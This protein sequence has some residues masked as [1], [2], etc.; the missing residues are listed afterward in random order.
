MLALMCR[1][2]RCGRSVG[3]SECAV[4]KHGSG[5]CGAHLN[6]ETSVFVVVVFLTSYVHPT[7]A[8]MHIT[9][10]L[11]FT[12]CLLPLPHAFSSLIVS[13]LGRCWRPAGL[14]QGQGCERRLDES[15]AT[16]VTGPQKYLTRRFCTGNGECAAQAAATI[17]RAAEGPYGHRR[18]VLIT[19]T[20]PATWLEWRPSRAAHRWCS[21][22]T[23]AW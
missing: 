22:T 14:L 19:S 3:A 16:L 10:C 20:A 6:R 1:V 8:P 15:S 17:I 4:E 21:A 5:L 2:S 12:S 11:S 23:P 9:D 13:T 18:Y 7:C